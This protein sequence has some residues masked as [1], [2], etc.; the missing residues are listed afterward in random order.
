[1]LLLVVNTPN[2]TTWKLYR[3]FGQR[4]NS[5]I[6]NL[7][8]RISVNRTN[9]IS[10]H[11]RSWLFW[12]VLRLNIVLYQRIQLVVG[13]CMRSTG[14]ITGDFSKSL[15]SLLF[16]PQVASLHKSVHYAGMVLGQA[17][18]CINYFVDNIILNNLLLNDPLQDPISSHRSNLRAFLIYYV[19]MFFHL[20]SQKRSYISNSNQLL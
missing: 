11:H 7:F 13:S 19:D 18:D 6:Y 2:R 5:V 9:K 10:V 16:A 8:H 12:S 3:Q 20:S 1:M 17:L 14:Q 15:L 4:H